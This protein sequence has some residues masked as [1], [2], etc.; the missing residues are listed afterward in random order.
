M[1]VQ[2]RRAAGLFALEMTLTVFSQP[3][4]GSVGL[5]ID[6]TG[7]SFVRVKDAEIS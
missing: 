6:C 2:M 1:V 3:S 7:F 4:S 5:G